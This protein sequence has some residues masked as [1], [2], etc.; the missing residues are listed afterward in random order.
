MKKFYAFAVAAVAALSM[1]AQTLYVCGAGDGL[2]WTPEAPFEVELT[3]GAY[4][5]DVTNLTQLKLSTAM[6]DWDTFNAAGK[7]CN[8]TKD[9]LG[10]A[11]ELVDGDGNIG[12]PW[13]GDYHIVIAGD[14]STI[15]MTTTTEEPPVPLK[16]TSAA[17]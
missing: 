7:T 11:I 14:L 17:P 6:G 13:K 16:S 1:N 10:N 3:D 8:Y 5:F 9:D 15:T 2:A 12:T 4:T